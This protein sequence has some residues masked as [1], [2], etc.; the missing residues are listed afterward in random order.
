[1]HSVCARVKSAQIS[2]GIH[3]DLAPRRFEPVCDFAV[4]IAHRRRKKCAARTADV[5]AENEASCLAAGDHFF[6]ASCLG[7]QTWKR[8]FNLDDECVPRLCHADRRREQKSRWGCLVQSAKDRPAGNACWAWPVRCLSISD[9]FSRTRSAHGI[10]SV[11]HGFAR[12]TRK[13]AQ[14]NIAN[15]G[16]QSDKRQI[17]ARIVPVARELR[18]RTGGHWF[19]AEWSREVLDVAVKGRVRSFHDD[20]IF[21]I[22]R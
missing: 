20:E 19:P 9:T 15:I 13:Y 3:G 10:Q 18:C 1:M 8:E 21:E 6:R 14:Q 11:L 2:G 4:K 17:G 22:R 5:F 7:S 12:V 16:P